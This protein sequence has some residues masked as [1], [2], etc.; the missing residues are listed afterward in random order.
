MLRFWLLEH[1]TATLS[2]DDGMAAAPSAPP[3]GL[4][5]RGASARARWRA[6][7]P[8]VMTRAADAGLQHVWRA[9]GGRR[10]GGSSSVCPNPKAEGNPVGGSASEARGPQRVSPRPALR[11]TLR[12]PTLS[13]DVTTPYCLRARRSAM[14]SQCR[15]VSPE[16]NPCSPSDF[17]FAFW[18][19]SHTS[20][21]KR[22]ERCNVCAFEET[23]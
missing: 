19:N 11:S 8:E 4:P 18:E 9:G 1:T 15:A 12:R 16:D 7:R 3:S 14:T 2:G 17:L 20:L 10:H 13:P 21:C 6:P 22:G 23:M 5:P